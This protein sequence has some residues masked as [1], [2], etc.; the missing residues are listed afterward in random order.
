[1]VKLNSTGLEVFALDHLPL[2]PV[3]VFVEQVKEDKSAW[4]TM[5]ATSSKLGMADDKLS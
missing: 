5:M 4:A 2:E 1:M 3:A